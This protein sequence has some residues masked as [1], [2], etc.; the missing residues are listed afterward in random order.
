MSIPAAGLLGTVAADVNRDGYDDL[1]TMSSPGGSAVVINVAH[2]DRHGGYGSA[3]TWWR[4]NIGVPA[5]NAQMLIGDFNADAVPDVGIIVDVPTSTP[6]TSEL[7]VITGK[8]NATPAQTPVL[9]WK[10]PLNRAVKPRIFAGDINGDGGADL[11]VM[12]PYNYPDT[13]LGS[14]LIAM[15]SSRPA[16]ILAAATT[17]FDLPDVSFVASTAAM[18][19]FNRDAKDDLAVAYSAADGST[20]IDVIRLARK[21]VKRFAL[22]NRASGYPATQLRLASADVDLDGISDLVL[23]RGLGK[24]GT[25]IVLL[26]ADYTAFTATM[27]VTDSALDWK[28]ARPF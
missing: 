21:H 8:L 22:W 13:G 1:L 7:L 20:H 3:T 10:G 17:W 27:A 15:K 16:N 19:D 18:G 26:H 25:Q 24:N 14:R 4:G 5:G 2:S 23:Y 12:Q 6:P 9:W 11:L 28:N